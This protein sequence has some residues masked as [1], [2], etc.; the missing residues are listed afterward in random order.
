MFLQ[1]CDFTLYYWHTVYTI[2]LLLIP[3]F[4]NIYISSN[5]ILKGNSN[6]YNN[7][8]QQNYYSSSTHSSRP[9]IADKQGS[10]TC[11]AKSKFLREKQ[12]GVD[13]FDIEPSSQEHLHF[14]WPPT[15]LLLPPEK[16]PKLH[17]C[18]DNSCIKTLMIL[19]SWTCKT[20][21]NQ[22]IQGSGNDTFSSWSFCQ[23]VL[24]TYTACIT[25]LFG[26]FIKFIMQPVLITHST[27]L[28]NSSQASQRS[29]ELNPGAQ[30]PFCNMLDPI[31]W[32]GVNGVP[33]PSDDGFVFLPI[34]FF[35]QRLNNLTAM[36]F[37]YKRY[38][39]IATKR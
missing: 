7:F 25:I 15:N 10:S 27:I 13:L 22:S 3:I 21:R 28:S 9:I 18:K 19:N 24:N 8:Q 26:D 23:T 37:S 16:F 36:I 11:S 5:R 17:E 4:I 1:I 6:I 12:L 34:N 14:P 33:I 30:I 35:M 32:N 20:I 2:S 29:I 39:P 31:L 38:T